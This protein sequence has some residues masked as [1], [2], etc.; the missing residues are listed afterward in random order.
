MAFVRVLR[1]VPR[2]ITIP[3]LDDCIADLRRRP[4]FPAEFPAAALDF[5]GGIAAFFFE[6]QQG[7]LAFAMG[8]HQRL[9]LGSLVFK[10]PPEVVR[11]ILDCGCM[12]SLEY[13]CQQESTTPLPRTYASATKTLLF[14]L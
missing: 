12:P 6:E 7:N 13:E 5:K 1:D 14:D 4:G 10:L 11:Q 3:Y 8:Q 2:R 9:G